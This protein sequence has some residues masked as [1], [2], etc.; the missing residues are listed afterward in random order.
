MATGDNVLIAG[1]IIQGS[2]DKR[3]I[4]RGIG[5][6]LPISNRLLDPELALF[7][8]NGQLLVSNDDW[9]QNPNRQEIVDTGIPPPDEKEA[10]LLVSLAPS[11]Y[12]AI[13]RGNGQTSG[14]GLV[15]V[16][17]LDRSGPAALAN[18]S[19]RGLVQIGNDVM[20]AG[21]IITGTQSADVVIR[22][23]GP[24]LPLENKLTDPYLELFD[25]N[26][27]GVFAN[28]NW[29]DA[30]AEYIEATGVAPSDNL[31]SAMRLPL[32]PGNYTAVVR[33]NGAGSG[34][35]VVEVYKL[36]P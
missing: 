2:G 22:A 21:M 15:E 30:Q 3:V 24:S 20:I 10:A 14:I 6:S 33:G 9:M 36:A 35:A 11:F 4:I 17:D 5:P 18:I 12:T 27:T 23:I 32:V 34:V 1:F 25:S 26:G 31:E 19:T 28:D 29:R 7:D 16:Y 8:S 13:V